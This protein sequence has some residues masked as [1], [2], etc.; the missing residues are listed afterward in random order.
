MEF[1]FKTI[2]DIDLKGKKVL[3]RLDLN[4]P[5]DDAKKLKDDLRIKA[6]SST[7]KALKDTALVILAHQGRYG[8]KDFIPLKQH[9]EKLAQYVKPQKVTFVDDLYG[10]KAIKA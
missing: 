3:C 2:S 10:D 5:V 8:E 7:V 4:S 9:A 1:K 6:S